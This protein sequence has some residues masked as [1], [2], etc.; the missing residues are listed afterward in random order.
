MLHGGWIT[1]TT[2]FASWMP[3]NK[4]TK[5]TGY[6]GVASAILLNMFDFSAIARLFAGFPEVEAVYLFGSQAEGRA[7]AGSDVDLGIVTRRGAVRPHK[8]VLLTELARRGFDRVDLLFIDPDVDLVMAFEAVRHNRRVYERD[9]FDSGAYF[10]KTVRQYFDFEPYLR[11]Q[12]KAQR[13]RWIHGE[14]GDHP[15]PAQQA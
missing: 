10:S 9:G 15:A 8:L 7:R 6:P 3:P 13:K 2:A 14:T 12:R 5:H 4:L 11:R 1:A